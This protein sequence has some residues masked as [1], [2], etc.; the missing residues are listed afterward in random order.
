MFPPAPPEPIEDLFGVESIEGELPSDEDCTLGAD[1]EGT[2]A[3]FTIT[4]EGGFELMVESVADE[5]IEL[6]LPP[7]TY[8]I[9]EEGTGL[10]AEFT[11][12]AGADT[13]IIVFNFENEGLLKVVKLF[14]DAET[15]EVVFTILEGEDAGP[16]GLDLPP[17][18]QN[19]EPGD[20]TFTLDDGPEFTVGDDGV[21]LIPLDAGAYV[22]AEVS[23]H[24][25][26]SDEFNVNADETTTV[27]VFNLEGETVEG[28]IEVTKVDEQGA[29]LP[30]ATFDLYLDDGDDVFDP[31]GTGAVAVAVEARPARALRTSPRQMP[32]QS[33]A[34]SWPTRST[35]TGGELRI[36][37][38]RDAERHRRLPELVPDP[39]RRLR[40]PHQR[41][42]QPGR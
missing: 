24:E 8:T 7:G 13:A 4:G 39:R 40:D 33:P 27:I 9:T 2:V 34:T 42:R 17:G 6:Q 10:S 11:I 14:C 12:E 18:A 21:R 15:T 37:P 35:M 19:C 16:G 30:G 22:L 23:P 41:R 25:A 20:A 38:E 26:T 36:G 28:D 1:D 32:R 3:H 5:I 31:E 29:T